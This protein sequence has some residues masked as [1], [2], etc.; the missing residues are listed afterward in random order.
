MLQ[1]RIGDPEGRPGIE[2][3][4][5]DFSLVGDPAVNK[6]ASQKEAFNEKRGGLED[7]WFSAAYIFT[8]EDDDNG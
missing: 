2:K 5:F 7:T 3:P 6:E 1:Q 8:D 4:P